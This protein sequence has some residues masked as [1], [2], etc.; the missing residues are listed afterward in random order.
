VGDPGLNTFG[1]LGDVGDYPSDLMD[2]VA[3]P[4]SNPA[5]W[6]G[7]YIRDIPLADG[8]VMGYY[9]APLEYF[10][11]LSPGATDQLSI[12]S[13]GP[14]RSSTNNAGDPNMEME[15]EGL[16]PGDASYPA[17][18]PDNVVYPNFYTNSASLKYENVGTIAYNIRNYDQ[19]PS[20]NATVSGCP[21]LYTLNF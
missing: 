9:G 2:L 13:K 15:F 8:S 20:Q 14:D 4:A 3:R 18:N 10:L 12:I 6:N 16:L 19:N 21:G 7:P 17:S 5:G 1:Y 11:G